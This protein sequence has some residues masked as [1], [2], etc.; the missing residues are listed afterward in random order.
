MHDT[1][2]SLLT[3]AWRHKLSIDINC[4]QARVSN[5]KW[6]KISVN[7]NE[8][9]MARVC[10]ACMNKSAEIQKDLRLPGNATKLALRFFKASVY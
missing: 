8:W 7:N 10:H 6:G 9:R 2:L 5:D 1:H 3:R 4:L